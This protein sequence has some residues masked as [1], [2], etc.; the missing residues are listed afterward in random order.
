MKGRTAHVMLAVLVMAA[1]STLGGMTQT[2]EASSCTTTDTTLLSTVQSKIQR[3][4]ETGRTDLHEMFTKSY[5]T[6]KGNDSYTTADIK[7]RADKQGDNWQ[8]AGPNEL[9]QKIYSE[10]D[11]LETCRASL[12]ADTTP[13]VITLTGSPTVT[14]QKGVTYTDAGAT[15]TDDTDGTIAPV[16]SGTVD[17]TT[18]GSYTITYSCTDAASNAATQVSRTITVQ[19]APDTTPPVITLTGNATVIIQKGTTYTDAGATCVD[20][21]DGAIVPTSSGTVDTTTVGPYTITYSCTDAANNAATQV[22]RVVIVQD[23]QPK[24]QDTQPSQPA[25]PKPQPPSDNLVSNGS[26]ETP[27]ISGWS[28][29][30][31]GTPGLAWTV[32]GGPL[33]IHNGIMG[34]ASDGSQH[35][36]LDSTGSITISQTVSTV[37]GQTYTVS[38]DYKARPDTAQS[39]NGIRV[40]W[41]GADIASGLTF[42]STWQTHTV[43]VNGTGSDVLSF[44]DAGTSDGIGTFLDN[45]SVVAASQGGPVLFFGSSLGDDTQPQ[46]GSVNINSMS[47]NKMQP[48]GVFEAKLELGGLTS[49]PSTLRIY[50]NDTIRHQEAVTSSSGSAK[51]GDVAVRVVK[52]RV[53]IDASSPLPAGDYMVRADLL[54]GDSNTSP[55]SNT[56]TTEVVAFPTN[57][58]VTLAGPVNATG[59]PSGPQTYD[60]GRGTSST[61]MDD[62]DLYQM[63][64]TMNYN[65]WFADTKPPATSTNVCNLQSFGI[66][67]TPSVTFQVQEPGSTTWTDIRNVLVMGNQ[68]P[69]PGGLHWPLLTSSLPTGQGIIFARCDAGDDTYAAFNYL[70]LN[71]MPSFA[72]INPNES[73]RP[74]PPQNPTEWGMDRALTGPQTKSPDLFPSGS[75]IRVVVSPAGTD[76]VVT[77]NEVTITLSSSKPV[78]QL[79]GGSVVHVQQGGTWTDRATCHTANYGPIELSGTSSDLTFTRTPSNPVFSSNGTFVLSYSCVEPSSGTSADTI[80][81]TVYVQQNVSPYIGHVAYGG[82]VTIGQGGTVPWMSVSCGNEFTPQKTRN[83]YKY[84]YAWSAQR[85]YSN[86][87]V[88]TPTLDK[89]GND[90]PGKSHYTET[91]TCIERDGTYGQS[92]DRS[93]HVRVAQDRYDPDDPRNP[94]KIS[95]NSTDT[96]KAGE[97]I[98]VDIDDNNG[99]GTNTDVKIRKAGESNFYSIH[100]WNA[101]KFDPNSIH[102]YTGPNYNQKVV[103]TGGLDP[104]DYEIIV[105]ALHTSNYNSGSSHILTF[106]VT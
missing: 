59:G 1:V 67:Y 85:T 6:M 18:A 80:T 101:L 105:T 20:N 73:Y 34:G 46:R 48:D 25:A 26:F 40:Q 24:P 44:I 61:G 89:H 63:R 76:R 71:S 79:N 106:T 17:T 60:A 100:H 95:L 70:G 96:V 58:T 53:D 39:T 93:V 77:S 7:A 47:S 37:T 78:I 50:M 4:A 27:I 21:T 42:G 55:R 22:S 104:G 10:L 68:N 15:C 56:K 23:A 14:I 8:G 11:R 51:D 62:G 16:S 82:D 84:Q 88:N 52:V 75:K 2:A 33:E 87:D 66:R 64:F 45:V 19:N 31:S 54:H 103:G 57:P 12:Q 69:Q 83:L 28:H 97:W 72:V 91:F 5:N 36:E 29:V 81:R 65:D 92:I 102:K 3:H 9:W 43:T 99:Y 30:S 94:I 32:S 98:V 13:P 49:D 38:F 74:W 35:V 86:V 90:I 41:N